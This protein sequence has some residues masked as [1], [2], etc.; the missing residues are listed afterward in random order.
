VVFREK[1]KDAYG[2]P[3]EKEVVKQLSASGA[4]R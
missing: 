4:K 1:S 2:R 3:Y